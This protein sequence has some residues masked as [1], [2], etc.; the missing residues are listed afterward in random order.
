LF[1]L[2][3]PGTFF[4][5]PSLVCNGENYWLIK[6]IEEKIRQIKDNLPDFGGCKDHLF[7]ME[8]CCSPGKPRLF[9]HRFFAMLG[10]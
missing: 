5:V 3:P 8:N 2:T 6:G 10:L 9:L 4:G 1:P 7:E